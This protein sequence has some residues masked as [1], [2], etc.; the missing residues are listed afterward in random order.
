MFRKLRDLWTAIDSVVAEL[1]QF[2]DSVRRARELWDDNSTTLS[3]P[4]PAAHTPVNGAAGRRQGA[5]P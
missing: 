3:R 2:G 1:R 5:K 4:A